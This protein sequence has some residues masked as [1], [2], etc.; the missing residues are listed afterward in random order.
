MAKG[1]GV[2][3]NPVLQVPRLAD[4]D[5]IALG[6]NHA[7]NAGLSWKPGDKIADNIGAGG[8]FSDGH[9]PNVVS[10]AIPG[11]RCPTRVAGIGFS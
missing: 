11:N 3:R 10:P 2:V 5:D 4:I 9:R 7:V 8:G 6:I 1:S